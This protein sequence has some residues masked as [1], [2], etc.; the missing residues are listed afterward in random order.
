M[1]A[2]IALNRFGLGARPGDAA[3]LGRG[4]EDWLAGQV[5]DAN[6]FVLT[7]PDLPDSRQAGAALM[8]FLAERRE[9]RQANGNANAHAQMNNQ[10]DPRQLVIRLAEVAQPDVAARVERALTT[11]N[12]FAERLVYF[13]CNHFTVAATKAQTIAFIGPFEREAVRPH[14]NGKFVDLL[15]ATTFHPGMLLYLDQAQS[16]GPNSR[17]GQ[18]RDA[19]LN[20]NLGREVME[21]HTVGVHGGY[22]QADVTEF[23]RALTGWTIVGPR[24]RRFAANAQPGE[25]RFVEQ[26]HEPGA[27]RI[28]GKT[29]AEGGREQAIAVLRDLARHP[30][31]ANHIAVKLTR[32]F[33]ADDPPPEAVSSIE[34][35]FLDTDGDLPSVH[36]ALAALPQAADPAL[37]KFKS[38]QDFVISACRMAGV[39]A[40][41]MRSIAGSF[42]MLGQPIFRAPS[43][44]GWDDVSINWAG[45]DAIMKRLEWAQA[46]ARRVSM[47]TPPADLA[48]DVLGAGLSEAT[49]TAIRRAESAEQGLTLALMS[50]EFQRR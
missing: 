37:K 23:A 47:R 29:Y 21:L 19:G 3:R 45:P 4:A 42:Q 9:R 36:R 13:W 15:T 2:A 10:N 11:D 28:M 44:A 35:V 43:P 8:A 50:P 49:R 5:G 32:H 41:P 25:T 31:T 18:R 46:L 27:R 12:G 34:R 17:L 1:D 22:T 16:I 40:A 39:E 48:A 20:E 14:L 33:I 30:A 24:M 6:S 7:R 26:M 38:P